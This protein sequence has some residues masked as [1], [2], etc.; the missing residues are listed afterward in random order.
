MS[1]QV[2]GVRLGAER[3][4][5]GLNNMAFVGKMQNGCLPKNYQLK[6]LD[7]EHNVHL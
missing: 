7:W 6:W 5:G 1:V 4:D 2:K 3:H